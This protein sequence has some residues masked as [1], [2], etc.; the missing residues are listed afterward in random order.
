MTISD[1]QIQK[2]AGAPAYRV[3][4]QSIVE[5]ILNGHFKP[6]DYL[7]TEAV[8]C[9]Q[10]HV[11]RS[12]VREGVRLLEET[13]M[14]RRVNGK[15]L[16]V[17]RPTTGELAQQMERAMRLHEVTFYELWETAM[18]LEPKTAALAAIHLDATD[19]KELEINL[20]KTEQFLGDPASLAEL[21]VEFHS[22]VARGVHNR[23]MLMT[24]E[25]MARLFYPA[26]EAVLSRLPDAGVR[27]LKAHKAIMAALT[28]ADAVEA[29][30]W[31]E[32]HIRDFR[33]GFELASLNLRS[34]SI[35]PLR[36]GKDGLD[37]LAR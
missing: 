21:D 5:Q 2:L 8:L 24:R 6:G 25:P 10:F 27:L 9:E 14:L 34:N 18:V 1:V 35:E 17:S 23:V 3:L 31:M 26:F 32:K 20:R 37:A 12:T 36:P 13:G 11:N 7:P 29:A 22:L 28:H 15:R 30:S 4:S 19:I 33:V 16:V